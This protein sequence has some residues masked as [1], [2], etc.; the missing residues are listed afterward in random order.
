MNAEHVADVMKT[1]V[2]EVYYMPC[3]E[4]IAVIGYLKNRRL[5][6]ELNA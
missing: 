3:L 6:E 2:R 5:I 1:S 4:V